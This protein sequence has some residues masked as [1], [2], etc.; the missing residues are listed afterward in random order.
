MLC[1]ATSSHSERSMERRRF[2]KVKPTSLAARGRRKDMYG[3][4]AVMGM[5]MRE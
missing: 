1:H 4:G 5:Q 2:E 3:A